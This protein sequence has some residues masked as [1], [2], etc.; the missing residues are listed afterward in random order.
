M[1]RLVFT[2]AERAAL[3]RE[4]NALAAEFGAVST[5]YQWSSGGLLHVIDLGFDRYEFTYDCSQKLSSISGCFLDGIGPDSPTP[6]YPRRYPDDRYG[7]FACRMTRAG[8][9][10]I[11]GQCNSFEAPCAAGDKLASA[12]AAIADMRAALARYAVQAKPAAQRGDA[13]V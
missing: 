2:K 8:H 3:A 13:H 11:S 5:P 4:V 10:A 6:P 7:S 12:R 9:N 1:P